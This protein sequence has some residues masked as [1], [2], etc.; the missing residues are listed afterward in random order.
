MALRRAYSLRLIDPGIKPVLCGN[1][2]HSNW[3]REVLMVM[4]GF[5]GFHSNHLL[6][7]KTA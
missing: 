2:S 3:D 6:S 5:V 7:G 4:T 1:Q